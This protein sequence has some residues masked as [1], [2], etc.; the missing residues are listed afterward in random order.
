MQTIFTFYLIA[1]F[2]SIAITI[3]SETFDLD[4]QP[5]WS[6]AEADELNVNTTESLADPASINTSLI[7]GDF[8]RVASMILEIVTFQ[9]FISLL[10]VFPIT[11]T[12]I[13]GLRVVFGA[14]ALFTLIY[15]IS[16]RTIAGS[17]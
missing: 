2:F 6:L 1:I 4:L 5:A 16:G 14:A 8:I 11:D 9:P 15:I 13:L 17:P 10:A 3:V 7:F 12:F